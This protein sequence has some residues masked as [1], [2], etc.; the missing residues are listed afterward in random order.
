MNENWLL[1]SDKNQFHNQHFNVFPKKKCSK[2]RQWQL[3]MCTTRITY[4]K[5]AEITNQSNS[6]TAIIK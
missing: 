3:Q 1:N 6:K 4:F 2:R 5:T